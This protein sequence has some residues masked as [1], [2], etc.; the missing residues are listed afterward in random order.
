[1][2]FPFIYKWLD[3]ML[4]PYK[5]VYSSVYFPVLAQK[6]DLPQL[7]AYYNKDVNWKDK[8]GKIVKVYKSF[9]AELMEYLKTDKKP[10]E[11][12]I[13]FYLKRA[14]AYMQSS[15]TLDTIY[16]LCPDLKGKIAKNKQGNY[17][18]NEK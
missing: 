4:C 9:L 1:M 3:N 11:Q 5:V 12:W 7:E 13:R 18:I 8:N 16:R 17:Y 14:P 2:A 15:T 6:K 10:S